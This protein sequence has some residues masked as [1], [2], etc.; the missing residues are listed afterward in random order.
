MSTA[1]DYIRRVTDHLPRAGSM[2]AQVQ[3]DLRGI[4]SER[5]ENGGSPAEV[6]RQLGDPEAL[7]LS[8]LSVVPLVVAPHGRRIVAKLADVSIVVASILP[9][10]VWAGRALPS[11]T[12]GLVVV[13][14]LLGGGVGFGLCTIGAEY[15]WGQTPGKRWAGLRVVRESGAAI[16]LGQSI[17]RQLPLVLQIYWIDGLFALFTEK[18]QRAFE[19]LSKTRVV[20]A[21]PS[22]AG[23]TAWDPERIDRD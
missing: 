10:L 17:V 16:G 9:I 18:K 15:W 12:A 11:D 6:L 20:L 8:Y 22:R 3:M 23:V 5:L 2:R 21:D 14:G 7:A 1:A 4:I 13:A 19:L